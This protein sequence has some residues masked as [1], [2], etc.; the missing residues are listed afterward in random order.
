MSKRIDGHIEMSK[1]FF[2]LRNEKTSKYFLIYL[3]IRY[4]FKEKK[5]KLQLKLT[6]A[7]RENSQNYK[8]LLNRSSFWFFF[9]P[10]EL[11]TNKNLFKDFRSIWFLF[12][13][14]IPKMMRKLN[15]F[16][17]LIHVSFFKFWEP[18]N[19]GFCNRHFT[20][21]FEHMHIKKSNMQFIGT[22]V[23]SED[24]TN[25]ERRRKRWNGI[26][27]PFLGSTYI[28]IYFCS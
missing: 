21:N 10:S 22:I 16:F 3:W 15:T 9:L 7:S 12:D 14:F 18:I 26:E 13:I 27:S 17:F 25:G 23:R 24:E 2:F 20:I 6:L 11:L 5:R 19:I 1:C 8:S 4:H 28:Y